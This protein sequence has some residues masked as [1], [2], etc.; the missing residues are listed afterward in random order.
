MNCEQAREIL[1]DSLTLPIAVDVDALAENHI[2]GC[3]ACRQFAQFQRSLD[4]R[5]TAAVPS[6]ALSSGFRRSLR[7]GMDERPAAWSEYLP[8]LAHLAG[9]ALAIVL[10]L[11][12]IP[13][14]S[15]TILTAGAGFTVVTYFVQAALRS[16]LER[17]EPNR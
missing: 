5:L 4:V 2:A 16:S 6:A 14:Y 11:L 13:A 1:L 10:L 15:K 8:D 12:V 9:C 17:L 7:A 3:E